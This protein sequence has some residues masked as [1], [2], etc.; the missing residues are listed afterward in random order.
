MKYSLSKYI[1]SF[2]SND[3]LIKNII[4]NVTIGGDGSTTNSITVSRATA[5]WS[6][7]GYAT[8]AWVHTKNL[9]KHGSVDVSINQ[10]APQIA[11]LKMLLNTYYSSDERDGLTIT[12][13]TLDGTKVASCIDCYLTAIPGQSFGESATDQTWTFTCG[14]VNF[15]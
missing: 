3:Q 10:L 14:E 6:T 15:D 8:G 2:D 12:V 4:G 13:S 7:T 5:T 1:V 9:D 11:R